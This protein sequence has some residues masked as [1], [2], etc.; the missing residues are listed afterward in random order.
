M[1]G[2]GEVVPQPSHVSLC[3]RLAMAIASSCSPEVVQRPA[4]VEGRPPATLALDTHAHTP[5]ERAKSLPH[6]LGPGAGGRPV[7]GASCPLDGVGAAAVE[8]VALRAGATHAGGGVLFG[9]CA[10]VVGRPTG[11]RAGRPLR[12]ARGASSVRRTPARWRTPSRPARSSAHGYVPGRRSA[13]WERSRLLG[14][15][16]GCWAARC[17]RAA[18]Q[19]GRTAEYDTG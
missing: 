17:Q 5:D 7:G 16:R 18:I 15:E 8:L 1:V 12:P 13:E 11:R 10:R 19:L 3:D 9:A 6:D 4:Q 2:R 14:W